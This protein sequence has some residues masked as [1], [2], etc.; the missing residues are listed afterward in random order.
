MREQ[1]RRSE[2]LLQLRRQSVA[3]TV[4]KG[5][6]ARPDGFSKTTPFGTNDHTPASDTLQSDDAEWFVPQRR[7]H[8]DLMC[9]KSI[10]QVSAGLNSRKGHLV[11]DSKGSHDCL[12]PRLLGS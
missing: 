3:I 8:H 9:V 10:R 5:N 6:S 2:Q 12:K 11:C 1:M 7:N 4:G